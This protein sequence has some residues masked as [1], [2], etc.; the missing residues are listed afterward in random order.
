MGIETALTVAAIAGVAASAAGTGA[1]IYNTN[2]Q[3]EAGKD[4]AKAQ[5]NEQQRL[6]DELKEKQRT[7]EISTAAKDARV[8]QRMVGSKL[9][10]SS[11]IL[12]SPLGLPGGGNTLGGGKAGAI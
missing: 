6:R 8:R 10:R 2:K 5:A 9:G 1:T 11:T 4:A 12:T 3:A 7:E